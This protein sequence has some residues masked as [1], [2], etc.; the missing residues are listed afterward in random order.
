MFITLLFA[1][2]YSTTVP[3]HIP[4]TNMLYLH[5]SVFS[6]C[7]VHRYNSPVLL[8]CV[9]TIHKFPRITSHSMNRIYHFLYF[10]TFLFPLSLFLTPC[11]STLSSSSSPAPPIPF[12]RFPLPKV[13]VSMSFNSC[14]SKIKLSGLFL[15]KPKPENVN[16]Y[17]KEVCKMFPLNFL[18]SYGTD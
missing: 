2:T 9:C 8:Q 18:V 11:E 15:Q 1:P 6:L 13:L 17:E 3:E 4:T 10:F 12:F 5:T 7:Q 16:D 14:T